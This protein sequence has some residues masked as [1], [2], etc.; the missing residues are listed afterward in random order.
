MSLRKRLLLI[1]GGTFALLWS[2]AAL[3]LLGDLGKEVERVL[4]ERLASSANMVAGLLEQ[5][6][7]PVGPAQYSP[8]TQQIF[9][10][11]RGLVCQVRNLRGEVIVRS[12]NIMFNEP[13]EDLLGFSSSMIDGEQWRTY[14]T[15]RHNLLITTG[16]KVQERA[17]LQWVIRFAAATPVLFALLGSLLLLWL[18]ISRGLSPLQQLRQQLERRK[19]DDLSPLP[20]DNIPREL[21]PLITTLNQ[22]LMR[23]N[24]MLQQERRFNDDAAHELRSPLTAIK[25]YLQVAQRAEPNQAV[26]YLDKAQSA[27]E[28]MQATMEQLLLLSR[29]SSNE[30]YP[31]DASASCLAGVRQVIE[32]FYTGEESHRIELNLTEE[33]DYLLG[34]PEPLLVVALRNLLENALRYS[35]QDSQIQLDVSYYEQWI[36][37]SIRDQGAGIA[38]DEFAQAQQ[39]FWRAQA[40]TRGS[41]LGLAIVA[42]ICQRFAGQLSAKHDGS[43][44][45]VELSLP[46]K[47]PG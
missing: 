19:A 11:R 15:Q 4:D 24:S 34:L 43:W 2:L 39:R 8:L 22:L 23:I 35:P 45:V 6:P 42:A 25:T 7:A 38:T 44:F 28:R 10:L 37:F 1:L 13:D 31:A 3:W 9:G 33:T 26:E 12:P 29:L 32:Y 27:V 30:D 21:L 18:G 16:D 5:I 40:N 41:G 14:T 36:K 46:I 47:S 17:H 20:T